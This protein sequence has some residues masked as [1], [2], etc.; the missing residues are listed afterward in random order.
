MSHSHHQLQL[1]LCRILELRTLSRKI[2]QLVQCFLSR[3]RRLK[4]ST[5]SLD[6]GLDITTF[7]DRDLDSGEVI[8]VFVTDS[9]VRWVEMLTEFS[10]LFHVTFKLHSRILYSTPVSSSASVPCFSL[11]DS[12][13]D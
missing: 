8:S 7:A 5:N 10:S 2:C 13:S 1:F 3:V 6:R 4:N 12:L 9:T 11:F